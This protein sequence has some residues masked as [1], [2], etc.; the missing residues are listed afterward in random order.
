MSRVFPRIGSIECLSVPCA[1]DQKASRAGVRSSRPRVF[2]HAPSPTCF[3]VFP[4][5][6]KEQTPWEGV[7]AEIFY[8]L[9]MTA[10]FFP[11]VMHL[12]EISP[13]ISR[14]LSSAKYSQTENIV[15]IYD[16]RHKSPNIK[17]DICFG[18]VLNA[19]E[20]YHAMNNICHKGERTKLSSRLDV[21]PCPRCFY[22]VAT[23][24]QAV[25]L[26]GPFEIRIAG[27]MTLH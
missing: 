19:H 5:V 11:L 14:L 9:Q 26:C 7:R 3:S 15:T 4:N 10:F 2:E 21:V 24:Q 1:G 23:V 18:F 17:L 8:I 13:G 6:S 25:A 20:L 27:G 16:S 22:P 12:N